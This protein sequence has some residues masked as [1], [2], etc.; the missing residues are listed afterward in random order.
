MKN[1]KSNMIM[2]ALVALALY[3]LYTCKQNKVIEK[4]T[5]KEMTAYEPVQQQESV[6]GEAVEGKFVSSH[7]LPKNDTKLDDKFD[8]FSPSMLKGKNFLEADRFIGAQS[9][10]LRN[11]NQQLRSEP[12]NPQTVVSPWLQSTILP[13]ERR[14]LEIGSGA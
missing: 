14:P 8:E 4:F 9:Q 12:M 2:I 7:L 5:S 11:A 1:D 10:S 6:E 13:D 3:I